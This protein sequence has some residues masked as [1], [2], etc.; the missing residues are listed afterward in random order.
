MKT[1]EF[2]N[3]SQLLDLANDSNS[4]TLTDKHCRVPTGASILEDNTFKTLE[5]KKNRMI[6]VERV[7]QEFIRD[8]K[9]K[10]SKFSF[11]RI[12]YDKIRACRTKRIF[13]ID[14]TDNI[15]NFLTLF[16]KNQ[17]FY[18]ILPQISSQIIDYKDP[19]YYTLADGFD[20]FDYMLAYPEIQ[21]EDVNITTEEIYVFHY[22]DNYSNEYP[23][24]FDADSPFD[25]EDYQLIDEWVEI[26]KDGR[27]VENSQLVSKNLKGNMNT[28]RLDFKEDNFWKNGGES[29]PYIREVLLGNKLLSSKEFINLTTRKN[30]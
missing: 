9:V 23:P 26:I 15:N 28:S 21:E 4:Q 13:I 25:K 24:S 20:E 17:D 7:D 14:N 30:S 12:A 11:S 10:L 29:K 2:I 18:K 16:T 19:D 22:L 6:I 27:R 8:C 1:D 5:F 3:L